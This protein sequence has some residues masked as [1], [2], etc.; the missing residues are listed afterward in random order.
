[1]KNIL[2]LISLVGGM[3]FVVGCEKEGYKNDGG[4]SVA[5]VNMTTYD[6][7]KSNPQFDSLVRIIDQ[8]GLQE[9]IN[10]DITFFATTN[11][12]VADYVSAKKQQK[13]IEV[14]DENITFTIDDIPEAE[15]SDSLKLYMYPGA[16]TRENLNTEG[17]Y[18]ENLMGMPDTARYRIQLDRQFSYS[19]FLDYVDY[20][21]FIKVI[22]TYDEEELEPDLI[23]TGK[24]DL[25][26]VC[27]T[28]G[29]MTTTG[30]VHVLNNN[31]R[32]FFNR[33]PMAGN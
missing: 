31:H 26:E 21:Y 16:V 3:W 33:Q 15:L 22:D 5:F 14:G 13:I 9:A 30:V 32:L 24:T 10:G 6:F 18:F 27:Q 2:I 28:S 1:M 4:K 23:P 8:A 29:I 17:A 20:L 7:L 11:Y 12:G 19:D 25:W